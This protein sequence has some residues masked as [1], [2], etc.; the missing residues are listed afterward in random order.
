MAGDAKQ[1]YRTCIVCQRAKPSN[2]GKQPVEPMLLLKSHPWSAVGVDIGTLPW[3]DGGY[4]YFL[5]MADLFTRQI[6][7]FPLQDQTY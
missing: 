5:L 6:D 7:L 3:L 2:R 4:R 1:F